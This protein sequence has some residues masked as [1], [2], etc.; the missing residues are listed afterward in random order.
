M[1]EHWRAIGFK[2]DS[3]HSEDVDQM[4]PIIQVGSNKGK[5]KSDNLT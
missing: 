2:P 4:E 3:D 1:E 5:Y